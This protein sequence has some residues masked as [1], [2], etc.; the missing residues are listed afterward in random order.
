MLSNTNNKVGT[1]ELAA[2]IIFTIGIK[3]TDTTPTILFKTA[4]NAGWI[5]ALLSGVIA[6]IS[7]GF[8]LKLLKRYKNQGLME[9]IYNL[10][11]KYIGCI[12]GIILTLD[13]LASSIIS[14]RSYVDILSNLFF[15]NTPIVLLYLILIFSSYVI[16]VMGFASFGRSAWIFMSTIIIITFI[17]IPLIIPQIRTEYLYP[18]AGEG[19]TQVLKGGIKNSPIYGEIMSLP[20]LFHFA[21]SYKDYK[22]GNL[23]GLLGCVL[24]MSGY[25]AIYVMA[26]DYPAVV[27]INYPFQTLARLLYVGRF[28]GNM[29]AIF[30]IFWVIASLIHFAV[31]LYI[32]AAFFSYTLRIKDF[33]KLILPFAALAFAIGMIPENYF[34]VVQLGRGFTL[35]A[36]IFK[37]PLPAILLIISNIKGDYKKG[38]ISNEA[39]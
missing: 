8:M 15:P 39:Q 14:T 17:F 11:G 37:Y 16:A 18:L 1:R 25:A 5:M 2:L 31:Y 21:R 4:K 10:T 32:G 38:D 20:V 7:L 36:G 19:V 33:E 23:L 35:P 28:V 26:F 27:V 6:F 9:I 24:L 30:L 29:E 13:M 34:Y 12:L 3:T 22:H